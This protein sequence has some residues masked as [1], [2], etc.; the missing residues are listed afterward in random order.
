MNIRI[1]AIVSAVLI[2]A[3]LAAGAYAWV[4]L[5][6][7]ARIAVHWDAAGR[8]NGFAHKPFALIFGPAL[9]AALG[10]VFAVIPRIEPRKFN[11]AASAKFYG[12]AWIG[13]IAV[14]AVAHGLIVVTAL[15]VAVDVG[16]VVAGSLSVLFIVIGNYLGKSRPNFFAGVRTPWTLSSEYSWEH[17]HRLAGKLFVA[18]GLATLAGLLLWSPK[19]ALFFLLGSICAT[20]VAAVVMSY[21]YWSRDPD[22]HIG[23]A[24]G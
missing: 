2:L 12:A 13:T 10:A 15:H 20:A 14:L 1:P 11:L 3:M 24:P 9:A 8:V 17:T 6:P 21:V 18:S 4:L 16:A 7:D 19:T 5:P 23:G 22:R